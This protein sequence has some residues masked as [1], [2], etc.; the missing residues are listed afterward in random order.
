MEAEAVVEEKEQ[1]GKYRAGGTGKEHIPTP[2]PG[3]MRI[4]YNN[5]NGFQM[6]EYVI[7]TIKERKM[8]KRYLAESSQ[9]TKIRGIVGVMKDWSVN[10]MCMSET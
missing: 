5:S 1:G 10:V 8:K 2:A 6:N 7:E 9:Y 3:S 4:V